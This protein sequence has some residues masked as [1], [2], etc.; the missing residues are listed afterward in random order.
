MDP[1]ENDTDLINLPLD[2][3]SFGGDEETKPEI[4]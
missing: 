1:R 4:A 3:S 2:E